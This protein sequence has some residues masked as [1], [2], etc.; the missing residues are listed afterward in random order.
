MRV[1]APGVAVRTVAPVVSRAPWQPE[2]VLERAVEDDPERR[3]GR[4]AH[5]QP[6]VAALALAL[7]RRLRTS[8][9]GSR[10]S[11]CGG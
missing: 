10:A 8:G 2:D 9:A 7:Q 6:R 3:F 5:D 4:V 1:R 11:R